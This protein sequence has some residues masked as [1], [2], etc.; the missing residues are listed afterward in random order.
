MGVAR[1]VKSI[2]DIAMM[3]AVL[4]LVSGASGAAKSSV[5]EAIAGDLAPAVTAVELRDLD[6]IPDTPNLAWRQRMAERAVLQWV[7]DVIEGRVP[8]LLLALFRNGDRRR[9][10]GL[11]GLPGLPA[12][13]AEDEAQ[14]VAPAARRADVPGDRH[15][16]VGL[17][18]PDVVGVDLLGQP[19]V[20]PEGLG[21][22][23][24]RIAGPR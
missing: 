9:D 24:C 18:L 13:R 5:R 16:L 6:T 4:L 20:R 17:Q 7:I 22:E 3:E 15:V 10:V 8:A 21:L 2:A 1:G 19:V 23:S 14:P 12:G 11:H